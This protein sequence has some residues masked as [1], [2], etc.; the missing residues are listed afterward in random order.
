MLFEYRKLTLAVQKALSRMI[1][2]LCLLP[3]PGSIA[4]AGYITSLPK[5][6]INHEIHCSYA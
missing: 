5:L 3:R 2:R 6:S 4:S 1:V